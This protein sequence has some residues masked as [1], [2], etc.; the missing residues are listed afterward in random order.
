MNISMSWLKQYVDIECDIKSYVEAMSLSGSNVETYEELGKEINNVVVGKILSIDPH[1]DAD[2]LVVTQIDVGTETIQIVTGATNI[3]VGDFVPVALH[4]STLAGG[5]KIK[6]GKLRGVVSNGMLCS[7]DELGFDPA[8]FPEAPED[9][10]YIFQQEL[11]LGADI[12]PYLGIDDIVVEYEITSNRPDCFSVLGIAREAAAT[13]RKPFLYPEVQVKENDEQVENYAKVTIENSELCPRYTARVVKNV[14]V[15]PSPAWMQQRLRS[16]GMRPINNIV[17][18]TNYVMLEMGQPLHAFDLSQLAGN[19]IIVR[20]AKEGETFVTLDEVERKL[21]SSMLLIADGEKAVAI[22]GVMGGE[23]SKVTESTQALLLESANF[24]GTNIRLTSKKLGLRTDASSKFEKGLDSELC[25]EVINRAAQLIVELG[26]GEV[27]GGV[28]DVYP[29]TKA[30]IEISYEPKRINALLGT[31]ISHEEMIDILERLECQVDSDKKV[32]VPPSF[33][34]DLLIEADLIEEIARLYGY[35]KIPTTLASGTPTVGK[36][37]HK[38]QIEDRTR[39][40]M[41]AQGFHESMSYSFES[42][43]VFDMLLLPENHP[44]RQGIRIANPLGEDFSVMRTTPLHGMLQSLS[45]NYNKRNEDVR[46]YELA[47]VYLPKSLPLEEL[48][49]ERIQLTFGMYGKSDFYDA[50]GV[51]ETFFE[52]LA[53]TSHIE[54][55]VQTNLPWMHPGR[56]AAIL[57]E[58]KEIGYVGEIHPKVRE[59][60]DIDTRVYMG[61]VDLPAVIEKVSTK[62]T[63]VSLP[64]YPAMIRDLALLVKEEVLVRMIEKIIEKHGGN[65]LE[66]Y[67]LFDVYQGQQIEKGY[68]SVAYSFVFRDRERTLTEEEVNQVMT[69]ILKALETEL[70]ATRREI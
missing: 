34:P 23:N 37:T 43:K 3:A 68:K 59:L 25:V 10:I 35:D 6:K 19:Q 15:G 21:D 55:A 65:L 1:P 17:D 51:V 33:R 36:Q 39:T 62:R 44:L 56:C 69:K 63:Y 70:E 16:A 38:Q 12:K 57:L 13:F 46:L 45:I 8:D 11:P 41:E 47:T 22:A 42:P 49:E 40:L 54:Y 58:G 27:V 29:K 31:Q 52:Q 30:P 48:P 50:K 4:G 2:K 7:L 67:E 60:H 20:N 18:I 53:L 14:K 24:N 9:G 26:A 66:S 5:L 32:V 28:I 61:V 64:R